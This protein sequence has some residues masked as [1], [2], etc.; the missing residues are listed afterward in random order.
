MDRGRRDQQN[1]RNS[2]ASQRREVRDPRV[3]RQRREWLR[4][5]HDQ[6]KAEQR[7]STRQDHARLGQR[8]VDL[9]VQLRGHLIRPHASCGT[10]T[11]QHAPRLPRSRGCERCQNR[12]DPGSTQ[13]ELG[14]DRNEQRSRK[15]D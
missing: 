4:Q 12:G 11:K 9:V 8:V 2:D 13:S 15:A 7:L 10:L 3:I 6:L 5:N 14:L 1:Y